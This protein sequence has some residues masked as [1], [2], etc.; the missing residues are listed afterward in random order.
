MLSKGYRKYG[1]V[2]WVKSSKKRI[3]VNFIG[4]LQR[5]STETMII[6][7]KGDL[8]GIAKYHTMNDVLIAPFRG[9]SVKPVE[10]YAAIRTLVLSGH[11]LEIFARMNNLQPNYVSLGNQLRVRQSPK[12]FVTNS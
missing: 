2:I 11:F 12:K 9:Q 7:S 4:K 5:H 10:M 6:F 8:A 1:K 3:P